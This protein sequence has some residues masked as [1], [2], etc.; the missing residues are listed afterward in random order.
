MAPSRRRFVTV[1]GASAL[2]WPRALEALAVRLQTGGAA[3]DQDFWSLVRSGF[4][5][6]DDRVYLNN[7]TLGPSPRI[8]VDAVAEH[9]RRVAM[10]YPPGVD[11]DDL[12][13]ALGSLL[14]GDPDGFVIPRN[15]TEAM[16]FIAHGLELGRSDEVVTTD[17]EHI[18]GKSAWELVT[19]RL[20][21]SLVR[22]PL[23][24]PAP[25]P[26]ALLEAVWSRVTPRTRVVM[27]SHVTFTNGTILPVAELARRCAERSIVFAV[28]GAHPPGML[29]TSLRSLGG[30]FYASSPHKWLLAP[31][32]SG[33]LY[34]AER[35]RT[36]LWPTLAS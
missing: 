13:R 36:E 33:L 11:W 29:R 12:G 7:G 15:T 23:P 3:G 9:T 31:Q 28:D 4:L 18:G 25:S 21:A 32:G 26:P 19:T 1:L 14:D 17:H 35:W 6:P 10:T 30:D 24:V 16:S 20:G 22:A 8:V 34:L 5:I 2:A 27:V